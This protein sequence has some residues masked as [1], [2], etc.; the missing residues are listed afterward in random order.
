MKSRAA[1]LVTTEKDL[2]NVPWSS[3]DGIIAIGIDLQLDDP[4]GLLDSLNLP[5]IRGSA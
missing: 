4:A 3:R 5:G 1:V 2:V